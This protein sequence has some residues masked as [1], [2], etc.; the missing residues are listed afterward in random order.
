MKEIAVFLLMM[1]AYWALMRHVL[2]RLGVP[3]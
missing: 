2:P 3:T 1:G